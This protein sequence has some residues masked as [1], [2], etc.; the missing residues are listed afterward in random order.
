VLDNVESILQGGNQIGRYLKG[1]EGYGRLLQRV[2]ESKHQSCLLVTSREKLPEVALQEGESVTTR[3]L[4]L[5]GLKPVAGRNILRDKGLQ[6]TEQDWE[7]L[8]SHYGGNPLA[9][10]LAA[11]EIRE[12]FGDSI[13]AFLKGGELYFR[14][15]CD[16]L[17]QQ[18]KRLSAREEEI[19][20][21]LAIE[22]EA[23]TLPDLQKNITASLSKGEL[24]EVLRSLRRRY[25]I[26]MGTIGF[27]LQPVI[28]EYLT[29]RLVDQVCEAIREERLLFLERHALLLAQA[30]DYIRESQRRFILWP[31]VQRLLTLFGG[32]VL[33]QRFQSILSILREQQNQ[34]L[35]YA[36]GNVLNL[37]IEMGCPLGDYDFSHLVVRQAYLRGVDLLGV[38]FA[39]ANLTTSVFT[40]SFTTIPCVTWNRE[41]NLLAAGTAVGEIRFW[42]ATD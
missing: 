4:H 11:Q 41:G 31:L 33:E 17:E 27:I 7:I 32:E 13:T 29:D 19:M 14:D 25:L 15:I 35:S 39:N 34:R 40:E 6:G 37:L 10:K 16:V 12:V 1:Y 5:G 22:R 3:S 18:M 20:Y 8:I 2:G 42:H 23:I 26:E 9:L 36:A 24:Q 30:K 28:M 21:W 38:N